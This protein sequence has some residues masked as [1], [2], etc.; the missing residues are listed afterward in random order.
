MPIE[1]RFDLDGPFNVDA[2]V[3]M[4]EDDGVIVVDLGDCPDNGL[5]YFLY[6]TLQPK[7]FGVPALMEFS[8][9]I[10]DYDPHTQH[11]DKIWDGAATKHLLTG[12]NRAF[13]LFL[14]CSALRRLTEQY[15]PETIC[16]IAMQPNLP[17]K[18]LSKYHMLGEVL[19]SLGYEF[20]RLSPYADHEAWM[21]ERL[22]K[23]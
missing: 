12:R 16:M 13:V 11:F 14:I 6:C 17:D 1:L 7:P 9:W 8:F 2:E 22:A 18:A 20:W 21:A 15:M 4:S 19:K 5:T 10:A 23:D 3:F